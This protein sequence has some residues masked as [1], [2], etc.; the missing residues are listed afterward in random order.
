MEDQITNTIYTFRKNSMEDVR[1]SLTIYKNKVLADLRVYFRRSE[2]VLYK[3]CPK[4]LTL[5]P[6]LVP[7]LVKAVI[8]LQREINNGAVDKLGIFIDTE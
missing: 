8:S 6:D 1:A 4:G 3:P 2:D 7:E 5:D